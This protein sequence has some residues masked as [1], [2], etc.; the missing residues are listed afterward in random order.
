MA[1]VN[2][3]LRVKGQPPLVLRRDQAY[4]GV[5]IDDLVTK[6]TVE[7]YRMFTSRAEYRLVLRQDNADL[8]LSE[9]GF[10]IGLLGTERYDQ[11]KRKEAAIE[12]ELARVNQ[13]RVGGTTLAELLRRPE[14]DYSNLP[15]ERPCL[16]SEVFE[17]VAIHLKYDGY[18]ARQ[19]AEIQKFQTLEA[20]QIPTWI[21]YSLI[22]SLRSEARQKLSTLRPATLGQASRISGVSPSDVSVLAIWIKRGP[23]HTPSLCSDSDVPRGT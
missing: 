4:I 12:G 19:A 10:Q 3:A 7:P 21:D 16:P 1:G 14:M 23:P 18:V 11:F 6:G 9:L 15:G 2:A 8:R 17:Q 20:K 13:T 22:R 5:L